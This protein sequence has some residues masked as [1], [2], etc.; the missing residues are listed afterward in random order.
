MQ[1]TKDGPIMMFQL[2]NEVGM[3]H[4]VTGQGILAI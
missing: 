1:V 2:D 4:W 3:L